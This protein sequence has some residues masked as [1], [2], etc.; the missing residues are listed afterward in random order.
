MVS[1]TILLVLLVAYGTY[2]DWLK[3]HKEEKESDKRVGNG[4]LPLA[5]GVSHWDPVLCVVTAVS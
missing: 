2:V 4:Y 3:M 1:I 5:D